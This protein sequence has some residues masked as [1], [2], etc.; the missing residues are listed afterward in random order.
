MPSLALLFIFGTANADLVA[1]LVSNDYAD[2]WYVRLLINL[3]GYAT[4]IVPG[5]LLIQYFRK[6]KYDEQQK[7][8]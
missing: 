4:I 2:L 5:Y 7:G 6:K 3:S 1:K 8:M